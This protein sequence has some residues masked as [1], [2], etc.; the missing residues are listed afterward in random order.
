MNLRTNEELGREIA[1]LREQAGMGQEEL[2]GVAGLDQTAMSKVE[3]G[4]RSLAAGELVMIAAH[5]GVDAEALLHNE[6]AAINWR[7]DG[8]DA[9]REAA[10]VLDNVIADYFAF[11][12][13]GR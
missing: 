8:S 11:E 7:A 10:K 12:A 9:T 6:P 4:K 5:L 13:V 2:G 3:A 1:R